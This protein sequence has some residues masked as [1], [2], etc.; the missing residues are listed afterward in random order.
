[1]A[2]NSKEDRNPIG[3]SA[4]QNVDP[5]NR[6][7]NSSRVVNLGPVRWSI[8]LVVIGV[9]LS[10]GV[11]A[12]LVMERN[13]NSP[14][15]FDYSPVQRLDVPFAGKIM[16]FQVSCNCPEYL[17]LDGKSITLP[18]RISY[19][20]ADLAKSNYSEPD[21][22][23]VLVIAPRIN[24]VWRPLNGGQSLNNEQATDDLH[25]NE[26]IADSNGP[27]KPPPSISMQ[28]QPDGNVRISF[29]AQIWDSN[30]EKF[31]N[32]YLGAAKF[33]FKSRQIWSK[34]FSVYFVC[35]S[36]FV[37]ITLC[38][39]L[40]D[41]RL[42]AMRKRQEARIAHARELA[43]S[44]PEQTR[45]AWQLARARLENYFDRNLLQV[46]LVFWVAISVMAAGFS[47]LLWGLENLLKGGTGVGIAI[48][49]ASG[50][51]TE[52]L[53]ATL[54]II[55]R[56][57]IQQANDY[58]RVLDRINN[59]GMAMQV[60]DQIAEEPSEFKNEVRAQIIDRLLCNAFTDAVQRR[61]VAAHTPAVGKT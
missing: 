6:P 28:L 38:M 58:I 23:T 61:A 31:T 41:N 2:L 17:L 51:L 39:F 32:Q 45:F 53:G 19:Q 56:T 9:A 1:M 55:Y 40:L 22:D 47:V 20:S 37:V 46:N 44:N 14:R 21:T 54:M 57:T 43:D 10:A 12:L 26:P 8:L 27:R 35:A 3:R 24:G 59:V 34:T 52:F 36:I 60:L 29:I 50:V 48:S 5:D 33:V 7:P 13:W 30:S 42:R 49:T 4:G 11:T 18:F 25:W 16:H 15:S